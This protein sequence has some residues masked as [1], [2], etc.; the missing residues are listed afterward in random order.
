MAIAHRQ[1]RRSQKERVDTGGC[2]DLLD[3]IDG[4]GVLDLGDDQRLGTCGQQVGI[5]R[6]AKPAQ[7]VEPA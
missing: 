2:R 7:R 3:R 5:A 6:V 4:F 1:V